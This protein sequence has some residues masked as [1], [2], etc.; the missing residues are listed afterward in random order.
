MSVY[1]CQLNVKI[2]RVNKNYNFNNTFLL[3]QFFN[4]NQLS[5][6]LSLES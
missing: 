4:G 3:V 6:T 2:L 1:V 5:L